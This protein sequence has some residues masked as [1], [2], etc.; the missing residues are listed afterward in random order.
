MPRTGWVPAVEHLADLRVR[1]PV[2]AVR[3]LQT[4]PAA[5]SFSA[6]RTAVPALDPPRV[7]GGGRY[8]I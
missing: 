1:P 5:A 7:P 3:G 2:E 8:G 6:R 4:F